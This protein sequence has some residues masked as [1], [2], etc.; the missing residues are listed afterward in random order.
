MEQAERANDFTVPVN[1][2]FTVNQ[3]KV[4]MFVV[5][6]T[7][8]AADINFYYDSDE[9]NGPGELHTSLVSVPPSSMDLVGSNFGINVYT[10]TFDIDNVELLGNTAPEPLYCLSLFLDATDHTYS[11]VNSTLTTPHE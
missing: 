9:G 1:T 7:V 5:S 8:N 11:Q 2:K 4:N 6:G 10:L 3:V